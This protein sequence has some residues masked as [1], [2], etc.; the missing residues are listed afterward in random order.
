MH[1]PPDDRGN[2]QRRVICD[3]RVE[4]IDQRFPYCGKVADGLF[5]R[6]LPRRIR[7]ETDEPF[8]QI[9][10]AGCSLAIAASAR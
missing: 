5:V 7:H 3:G 8:R 4:R 1:P 10:P 2:A 9:V 6:A